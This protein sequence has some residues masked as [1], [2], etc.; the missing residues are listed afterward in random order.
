MNLLEIK[1][2]VMRISDSEWEVMRVIWTMGQADAK[3]ITEIISESKN[4]KLATV[5]TLLGRLVKK[6]MILPETLGKKFIY[7]PLVTEDQ[8][9]R[10]ASETLFSHICAKKMGRT[11]ADFISD[12]KLTAEDIALLQEVLEKKEPAE[13]I[14]CDCALGQCQCQNT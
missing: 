1:N 10:Q 11:L 6:K 7:H 12:T 5:K 14:A 4:W 3:Q 9:V 13:K 2:E 8:T